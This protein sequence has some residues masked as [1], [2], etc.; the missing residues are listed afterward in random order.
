MDIGLII[1]RFPPEH[2]GGAENQARQVAQQLAERGHRVVVFTRRYNNRP[3]REEVDGYLIRRRN[4]IPLPGIRLLWD[5]FPIAMQIANHHPR[6]EVLLCYQTLNS[7]LIGMVSQILLGIPLILSIRS[8]KEYRLNGSILKRLVVLPIFKQA[9]RIVVQSL[10]IQKDMYEQLLLVDKPSLAMEILTKSSV[11]PN[12]I[13]LELYDRIR[14]NKIIYVGR[15]IK[16][17]G[18][19]DLIRAMKR[20]PEHELVI[21]GDGP[22]RNRLE[23]LSRDLNTTFIGQVDS[24]K[25]RDHLKQARLLVLPSRIDEGSPNVILEAMACG[26]PVIATRVGGIPDLV[27]HGKTGY[28]YEPGNIDQMVYF[29]KQV[30][31][32]DRVWN[33]L[34]DSSRE[35]VQQ[36]SW[37]HVTPQIEQLLSNFE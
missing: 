1:G 29:I 23:S 13:H 16:I 5:I 15:L 26:I 25:V 22:D 30:M 32:D 18:V 10:H 4:V 11:I 3:Y 27:R 31:E 35:A 8:S 33:E 6:P 2:I 20:L 36:Y 34:G 37:N 21:V 17:K 12:G 28:L 19:E 14:G 7:G 9:K 24:S